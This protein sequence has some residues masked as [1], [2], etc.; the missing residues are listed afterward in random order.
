MASATIFEDL[1]LTVGRTPMVELARIG[2]GLPARI[3]AKFEMRNFP[4]PA[5]T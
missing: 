4:R 5:R 3:V 2:R 1:T